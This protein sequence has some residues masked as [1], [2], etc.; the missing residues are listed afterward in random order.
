MA[1]RFQIMKITLIGIGLAFKRDV[2]VGI[3]THGQSHH[4]LDEIGQVKED[5]QHL[6]L[7]CSVD[8]LVVHQLFPQVPTVTH[9]QDSQQIK[10]RES[11]A[12]QNRSA[13]Y[14][15]RHKGTTFFEIHLMLVE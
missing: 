13:N 1:P 7:L 15:H 4:P 11:V 9:S 3:A 2:A 6:A 8:A 10:G 14:L 12:R 5:K